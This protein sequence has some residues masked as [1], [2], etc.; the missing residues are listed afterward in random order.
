MGR[1]R[2]SRLAWPRRG[3]LTG[4]DLTRGGRAVIRS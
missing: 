1:Q 3:M 2:Q 4:W